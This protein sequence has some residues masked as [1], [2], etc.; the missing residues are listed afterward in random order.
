[1]DVFPWRKP[2]NIESKSLSQ[3]IRDVPYVLSCAVSKKAI[4]AEEGMCIARSLG[5]KIVDFLSSSLLPLC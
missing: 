5:K 4:K 1:M 3:A 2:N